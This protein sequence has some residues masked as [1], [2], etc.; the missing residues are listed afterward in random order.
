[1]VP[2]DSTGLLPVMPNG[3]TYLMLRPLAVPLALFALGLGFALWR[4]MGD[5]PSVL[6]MG[7]QVLFDGMRRRGDGCNCADCA[8]WVMLRPEL[9]RI[10]SR[11]TAARPLRSCGAMRA[12]APQG[13]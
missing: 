13:R 11:T 7:F 3:L 12:A 10:A 9:L 8:V 1:M 5:I 4:F 6:G 2:A